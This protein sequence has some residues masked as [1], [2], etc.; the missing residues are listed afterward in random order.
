GTSSFDIIVNSNGQMGVKYKTYKIIIHKEYDI[1]YQEWYTGEEEV[2]TVLQKSEFMTRYTYTGREY[3]RETGQYYYRARTYASGLG[4]FTG[5]DSVGY[6]GY[7]YVKNNPIRL[8]DPSG[9]GWFWVIVAGVLVLIIAGDIAHYWIVYDISPG[10][11]VKT[12]WECI[13]GRPKKGPSN[14]GGTEKVDDLQENFHGDQTIMDY[15][16]EGR[17]R[18]QICCGSDELCLIDC[19]SYFTKDCYNDYG[20]VRPFSIS[21]TTMN[22]DGRNDCLRAFDP[23]W[24]SP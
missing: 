17:T 5:K 20:K 11:Y 13:P 24:K 16:I 7:N 23:T 12:W 19:Q 1:V 6:P 4:R 9:N 22:I 15:C 10:E 8:T 21:N 3:N 18:C 2:K 14:V